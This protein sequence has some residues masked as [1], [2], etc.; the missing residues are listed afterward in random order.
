MLGECDCFHNSNGSQDCV[1]PADYSHVCPTNHAEKP[2]L[3]IALLA[4][5]LY[6]VGVPLLYAG[7]IYS[8][9][10]HIRGGTQTLLSRALGFLHQGY[11]PEALWWPLVE[12]L[13]VLLLTG[14]LALVKPG[15]LIQIF[16]AVAV[17]IGYLVLHVFSAPYKSTSNNL[18]AMGASTALAFSLL[19]SLGVQFNAASGGLATIHTDVL[20][21]ILFSAAAITLSITLLVFCLALGGPEVYSRPSSLSEAILYHERGQNAEATGDRSAEPPESQMRVGNL[22]NE[23]LHLQPLVADHSAAIQ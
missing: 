5:L 19:G 16:C 17:A 14:V 13:R 2:L 23:P 8:V 12:A 10:S 15:R 3:A 18:V 21:A 11:R 4:V 6:G 20:S 7:L 1:L 22:S 9:R